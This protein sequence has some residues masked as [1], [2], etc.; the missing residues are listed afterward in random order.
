MKI[1]YILVLFIISN[2]ANSQN[3]IVASSNDIVNS[4]GSLSY[5][6]GLVDYLS[7]TDSIY[8]LNCGVQIPFEMFETKNSNLINNSNYNKIYPN[9]TSDFLYIELSEKS[10]FDLKYEVYDL[11]FHKLEEKNI[12][13][14]VTK[15]SLNNFPESLYFLR[16][17]ENSNQIKIFKIIK[18]NR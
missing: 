3:R 14:K 12:T 2:F 4:G 5:S 11:N 7:I 18:I 17:I 8:Q 1:I 15:I 13:E 10:I 16:I 9:P 6:I